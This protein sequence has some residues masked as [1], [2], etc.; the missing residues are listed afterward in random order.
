MAASPAPAIIRIPGNMI[1]VRYEPSAV[2]VD[3]QPKPA[4]ATSDP[5]TAT[6]RAPTTGM[7]RGASFEP[8]TTASELGTSA[9]PAPSGE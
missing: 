7:S 5:M 2:I 8:R 6:L 1:A 4:A 3:C 9:S